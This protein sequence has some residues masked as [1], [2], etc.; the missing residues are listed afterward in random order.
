MEECFSHCKWLSFRCLLISVGRSRAQMT[1]RW[2][3]FGHVWTPTT[4]ERKHT[5]THTRT[6]IHGE[7][8]M[9]KCLWRW[10]RQEELFLIL[11]LG[12][13]SSFLPYSPPSLRDSHWAVMNCWISMTIRSRQAGAG[14]WKSPPLARS[15]GIREPVRDSRSAKHPVASMPSNKQLT[16][17]HNAV[18]AKEKKKSSEK[19]RRR[20]KLP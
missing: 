15:H 13:L 18:F 4:E 9:C 1:V 17:H 3:Y 5:H 2:E 14:R 8:S 16:S 7:T 11:L 6:H 20:T 19:E 12:E 10:R